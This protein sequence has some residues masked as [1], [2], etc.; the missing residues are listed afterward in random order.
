MVAA[1]G[2]LCGALAGGIFPSDCRMCESP[3]TTAGCHLRQFS[4]IVSPEPAEE[5]RRVRRPVGRAGKSDE[6]LR[7]ARSAGNRDMRSSG[8]AAMATKERWESVHG[9]FARK[10][11][12]QV[13]NCRI[14]LL[15][16][17]MTTGATLDACSHALA[18]AGASSV[19][20]LTVA[21]RPASPAG[22]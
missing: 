6:E 9:A 21:V 14:L 1:K 15:D 18:D 22:R 19:I 4:G 3:P 10:E 5:L 17:V 8:H 11:G 16:D 13:D 12:G 7:F 2:G 20:A